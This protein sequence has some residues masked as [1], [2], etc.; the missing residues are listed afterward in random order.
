MQ[1]LLTFAINFNTICA[2]LIHDFDQFAIF[3]N[4]HTLEGTLLAQALAKAV[5]QKY[6]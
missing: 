1:K 6:L 4:F 5:A 2:I 3:L